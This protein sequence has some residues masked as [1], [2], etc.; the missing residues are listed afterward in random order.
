MSLADV[1]TFVRRSWDND[2]DPVD[3]AMVKQIRAETAARSDAW[4]QKELEQVK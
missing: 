2:A 1:L 4:T 3:A